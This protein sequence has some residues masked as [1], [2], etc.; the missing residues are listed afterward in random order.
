MTSEE[1]Y[2]DCAGRTLLELLYSPRYWNLAN[3]TPYQPA[4]NAQQSRAVS[5]ETFPE[6]L[7]LSFKARSLNSN[8]DT[9]YAAACLH[10]IAL[11]A[12][13]P[14]RG[15]KLQPFKPWDASWLQTLRKQK[16]ASIVAP[17]LDSEELDEEWTQQHP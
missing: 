7:I 5:R 4:A 6:W 13:L 8:W 12:C 11:L 16:A 1:T 17:L 2:W 9:C 15:A 10:L 3:G 14:D